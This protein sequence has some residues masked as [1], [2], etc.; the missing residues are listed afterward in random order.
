MFIR[1]VTSEIDRQ[2]GRRRG[3]FYAAYELEDRKEVGASDL[4]Q[5]RAIHAWFS[6]N[7]CEPTRLTLSSRP[8]ATAQALSWFRE[9]AI[10]HIS[11]MREMQIVLAKHGVF[12]ETLR[13]SRPGYIVYEDAH[14]VV[15]HP[16]ADTPN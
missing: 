14:Q 16:F 6:K 1:F 7:M 11:K 4:E 9:T 2:S 5:L 13:T 15:A 12:A 10:D 8:H 3:L